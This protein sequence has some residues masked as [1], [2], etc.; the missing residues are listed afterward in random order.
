MKLENT[1][2]KKVDFTNLN[3]FIEST[4]KNNISLDELSSYDK[5]VLLLEG[6]INAIDKNNNDIV[7]YLVNEKKY[8]TFFDPF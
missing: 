3:K 4:I 1:D 2:H 6:V 7:N 5:K 8:K